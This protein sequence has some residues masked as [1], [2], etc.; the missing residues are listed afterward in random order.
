MVVAA[1]SWEHWTVSRSEKQKVKPVFT[2]KACVLSLHAVGAHS[3]QGRVGIV[4]TLLCFSVTL[5]H[6]KARKSV[7]MDTL[8]GRCRAG[9]VNEQ[10]V[11]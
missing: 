10:N 7:L 6:V 2:G 5:C 9:N 4:V 1:S 8:F 11:F 3:L